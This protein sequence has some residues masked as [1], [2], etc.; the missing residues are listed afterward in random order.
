MSSLS[1]TL[2][3]TQLHWE[4]KDA[5]LQMLEQKINAIKQP[6]HVVV[7]P[8]MFT[9]SVWATRRGSDRHPLSG[10]RQYLSGW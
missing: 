10:D 4:D 9:A 2:V 7:L 8:E 5:N 1:F 6:T 3:Q